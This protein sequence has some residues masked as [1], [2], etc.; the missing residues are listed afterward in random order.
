ME[1]MHSSKQLS[2]N[3]EIGGGAATLY[4]TLSSTQGATVKAATA[5]LSGALASDGSLQRG[6]SLLQSGV[7]EMGTKLGAGT[8]ELL[9]GIGTLQEGADSLNSG[10]GTLAS[11]ASQLN[12]RSRNSF[13][14]SEHSSE[15][16]GR[17]GIWCRTA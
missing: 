9:S 2:A 10:L 6:I 5:G 16:Y 3:G 4:G 7:G 14:R 15:Q 8:N 13:D 12:E 1:L 11:G 17:T